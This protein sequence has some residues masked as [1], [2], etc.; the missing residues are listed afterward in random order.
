VKRFASCLAPLPL[1][2]LI[3][4]LAGCA[5]HPKVDWKARVGQYTYDQAILEMGPPERS[6]VISDGRT[7]AQW[8]ERRGN[9]RTT[10]GR[11][12]GSWI[13]TQEGAPEPDAFTTLTF[14]AQGV[15][16]SWKRVYR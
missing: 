13:Y 1:L 8:L 3:L 10:L 12:P 15:L 16:Q 4:T 14:D 2:A 7:V 5:T 6:A 11:M 9:Q